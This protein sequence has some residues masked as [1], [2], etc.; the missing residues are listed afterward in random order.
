MK[1]T[2][3]ISKNLTSYYTVVARK[4]GGGET[5]KGGSYIDRGII[6]SIDCKN[7]K[8]ILIIMK[9]NCDQEQF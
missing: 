8:G 4:G 6:V 2:T 9:L 5:R 7:L 3:C 1:E